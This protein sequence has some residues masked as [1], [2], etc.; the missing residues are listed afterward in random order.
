[1]FPNVNG[2][3]PFKLFPE[4]HKDLS[5]ERF[6]NVDGSWPFKLFPSRSRF[7]SWERF[8]IEGRI[9]PEKLEYEISIS[10]KDLRLPIESGNPPEKP[11]EPKFND[12]SLLPGWNFG[13]KLIRSL[14]F[15]TSMIW[16]LGSWKMFLGN[17]PCRLQRLR[18]RD[19]N[20]DRIAKD[21]GSNE[22]RLMQ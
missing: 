22:E 17:S 13:R 6:P 9:G 7:T 20:E 12:F 10:F 19:V 1:M 21:W 15:D 5:W 14:L 18:E 8:Q 16:K 4:R 11:V 2:S 3:R